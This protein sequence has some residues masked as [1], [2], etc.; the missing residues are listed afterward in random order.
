[1]LVLTILWLPVLIVPLASSVHGTVAATFATVDYT[2]WALFSLEYI[3]KIWLAPQR[4]RFFKTHLL[5]LLIVAV[6]FFRPA[7]WL[8]LGRPRPR[9]SF[10]V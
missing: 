6:P 4:G 7:R 3:I 9:G 8:D 10:A 2:V 5:D 1:M